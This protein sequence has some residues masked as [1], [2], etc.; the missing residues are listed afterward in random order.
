MT[1][2]KHHLHEHLTDPWTPIRSHIVDEAANKLRELSINDPASDL[3]RDLG[4]PPGDLGDIALPV[5][6]FAKQARLSPQDLSA[7]LSAGFPLGDA[8][9]SVAPT[10]G[11]LNFSVSF[12]WLAKATLGIVATR[13][14]CYGRHPGNRGTICV[15]HTSANPTGQLHV[16]RSRNSIIGDTYSRVLKAAGFSVKVHFYVDDIGRQA[17]ILN[18]IW[19]KPIEEWP[20]GIQ[21]LSRIS[22]GDEMPHS[23]KPDEWRGRP[24]PPTSTYV[25]ENK[26][27]LQDVFRYLEDFEHGKIPPDQYRKIPREILDGVLKSLSRI[28]VTFD[29]FVWESDF[30]LDGSVKRVVDTLAKVPHALRDPDGALGVDLT[31]YGLP[32]ELSRLFIARADGSSLYVARDLAY[33]EK[34]LASFDRV[35]DVLGEDHKNHFKA[36]SALLAECDIARRPEALFYSFVGLPEGKMSTRAGTTVTLDS[37][38]DEARQR[39]HTEVVARRPDGST[40]EADSIAEKVGCGA[41]RFHI[42][43]IQPDKPIVFKW[44]EALS[45]EGK[46][47]PFVQYAYARAS[48]LVRKAAEAGE[49]RLLKGLGDG[50]L[51]ELTLPGTPDVKEVALLKALSRFPSL[52]EKVSKNGSV[53]LLAL[54]AHEVSERFNEFYQ[55]VRVLGG[56]DAWIPFR[57]SLVC[58]TRQVLHNIL[59]L[60]GVEPLERM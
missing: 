16:G 12:D 18:W 8:L 57:L 17:A 40:Q 30:I 54:Y 11:F 1:E 29:E 43:A 31:S 21:E 27:V 35:I 24:Y 36:L 6:R 52:V 48:S 47:G 20:K 60:I 59:E 10:G 26:D 4:Q 3:L 45:F 19:S 28:G 23:I 55:S 15:E 53:H 49:R 32:E 13:G 38:L 7:K 58:A 5:F 25:K 22:P 51:S 39:A 9:T 37:L 14:E 50:S 42:L 34:K 44:E 46:S 56:E 41:V 2:P 33:H